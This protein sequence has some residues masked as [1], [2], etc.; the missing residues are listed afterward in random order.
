MPPLDSG[1]S[2]PTWKSNALIV[3]WHQC[4]VH[5]PLSLFCMYFSHTCSLRARGIDALRLCGFF[6]VVLFLAGA[7]LVSPI[8]HLLSNGDYCLGT[9]L[10]RL[11]AGII[12]SGQEA[13]PIIA[14]AILLPECPVVLLSSWGPFPRSS[15]SA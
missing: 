7:T 4:T 10:V 8:S 14:Q 12:S 15:G 1:I 13:L 9:F 6:G 2:C 5:L 3:L 11:F